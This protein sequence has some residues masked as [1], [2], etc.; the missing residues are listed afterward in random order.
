MDHV[1]FRTVEKPCL[2]MPSKV[3][4]LVVTNDP[5]IE[6]DIPILGYIMVAFLDD[7]LY[8]N[9]RAWEVFPKQM[10][11]SWRAGP[12]LPRRGETMGNKMI[13]EV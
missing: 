9:C 4:C 8:K 5:R 13:V 7:P 11:C 1:S 10:P 3:A 6:G 2:K 12:S